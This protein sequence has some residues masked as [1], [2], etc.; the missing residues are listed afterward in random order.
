MRRACLHAAVDDFSR[1]ILAW[2]SSSAFVPNILREMLFGTAI[3]MV[4]EKLA[5]Q[6]D[7]R[8]E[9]FNSATDELVDSG[10]LQQLLA[11]TDISFMNSLFKSWWPALCRQLSYLNTLSWAREI[12]KLIAVNVNEHNSRTPHLSFYRQA[13]D[14]ECFGT[15]CQI[16]SQLAAAKKAAL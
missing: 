13:P 10:F 1:R 11:Q 8:V 2:R 5:L 4:D 15:R 6:L 16:P 3:G 14:E 7:S 12:E 9:D